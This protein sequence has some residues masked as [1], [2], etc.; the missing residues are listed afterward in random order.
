MLGVVSHHS[1]P[2]AVRSIR[3]VPQ[4]EEVFEPYRMTFKEFKQKKKRNSFPSQGFC[5]EKTLTILK[6]L[7]RQG[8]GAGRQLLRD[9]RFSHGF[10]ESNAHK[11]EG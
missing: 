10:M 6:F 3:I 1:I 5:K 4:L 2:S 11:S 9:F 8:R 7:G